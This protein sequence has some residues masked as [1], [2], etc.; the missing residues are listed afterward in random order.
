MRKTLLSIALLSAIPALTL[1]ADCT[2]P[3][4]V[5]TYQM[6]AKGTHVGSLVQRLS[7]NKSGQYHLTSKAYAHFLFFHDTIVETSSG[8]ITRGEILPTRYTMTSSRG[9]HPVKIHFEWSKGKA[10]FAV[11]KTQKTYPLHA[12]LYDNLS[13][14]LALRHDLLT[15]S[16][17]AYKVHFLALG[18]NHQPELR[19]QTFTVKQGATLTF[20]RLGK[21]KTVEVQ[22][23]DPSTQDKALFWFAPKYGDL[24]VKSA[25][26]E[27]GGKVLAAA[28]L[29][30][31]QVKQGCAF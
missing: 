27:P 14:Q 31:Y 21:V 4:Y 24:L 18:K 25:T 22:A 28:E 5:A 15:E 26:V 23:T 8:H 10:I 6:T 1:A 17:H 7:V 30:R 29:V 19:T 2:F 9:H 13:Y 12:G 20:P 16:K 11:G 3:G